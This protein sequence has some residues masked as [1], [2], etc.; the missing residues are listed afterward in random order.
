MGASFR[1]CFQRKNSQNVGYSKVSFV[2]PPRDRA[3]GIMNYEVLILAR[4]IKCIL[5]LWTNEIGRCIE[6]NVYIT[7]RINETPM[8]HKCGSSSALSWVPAFFFFFKYLQSRN[9]RKLSGPRT[10]ILDHNEQVYR[11]MLVVYDKI[12][13]GNFLFASGLWLCP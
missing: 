3:E 7:S 13:S 12:L 6:R 2:R 11:E 4:C 8:Y 9:F 5:A 1:L 10:K